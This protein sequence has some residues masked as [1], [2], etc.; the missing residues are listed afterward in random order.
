MYLHVRAVIK[1][2]PTMYTATPTM[3][4][5]VRAVIKATPKG[6][7]MGKFTLDFA[8]DFEYTDPIDGSVAKGQGL[9]F[10]FTGTW[11]NTM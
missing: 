5:Q 6:T 9:R 4:S 3:Y 8:D 7:A 10:V 1:A 2:T 11:P